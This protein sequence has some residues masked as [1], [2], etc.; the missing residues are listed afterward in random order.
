MSKKLILIIVLMLGILGGSYFYI[1]NNKT[2]TNQ[3]NEEKLLGEKDIDDEE[4]SETI[5]DY[6]LINLTVGQTYRLQYDSLANTLNE[7]N[8]I[9]RDSSIVSVNNEGNIT[10]ISPGST[11]VTLNYTGGKLEFYVTV[12]DNYSS[13]ASTNNTKIHFLSLRR[14]EGTFKS[15]DA[16]LLESNGKY[17]L[18]DAGF[19]STRASLYN[20]L[21][22]F[23]TNG[24]LKLDFVLITH[25]HSDHIGGLSYLLA[26]DS[27]KV[28]TLYINKYYKNDVSS[29]LLS[30]DKQ[31]NYRA[32]TSEQ[33]KNYITKNQQRYNMVIS[34]MKQ[35]HQNDP[36][37]FNIHYLT[38]SDD[39]RKSDGGLKNLKLGNYDINLYNTRQQLKSSK[40][41]YNG[42]DSGECLNEYC[43][44]ADGNINTVVAKVTSNVN[45][46]KHTALLTGDLNYSLLLGVTKAAGTVDVFKMPHHGYLT[47]NKARGTTKANI[48]NSLK[49]SIG[50]KTIVVVTNKA[51]SFSRGTT[52]GMLYV[53]K[54]LGRPV[55]YTGGNDGTDGR[56]VVIDFAKTNLNVEYN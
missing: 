10:G 25:N 44:N 17:G 41:D 9:S 50:S 52:M 7:V 31:A 32:Y 24:I 23:A 27:I 28:E 38:A 53:S 37:N 5:S 56:A 6:Q 36:A 20:Y 42:F 49:N 47:V 54:T 35:R 2:L 48:K 30:S 39:A 14:P 15:C 45:G 34:L 4:D 3:E 55:Y 51:S 22:Q 29:A 40:T 11:T 43:R 33:N 21:M 12:S 8:F 46:I 18:V 26:Q 13:N 1:E 19:A 16:I